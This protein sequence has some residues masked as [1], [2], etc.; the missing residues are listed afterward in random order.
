[1]ILIHLLYGYLVIGLLVAIWFAFKQVGHIDHAA[2]K[3]PLG[4][5]LLIL[6]GSM[7]LWPLI[8]IKI[9]KK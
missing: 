5:R 9:L 7:L 4:F 6:P 3:T 8:L 1:M 2:E